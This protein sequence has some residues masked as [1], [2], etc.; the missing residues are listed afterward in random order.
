VR[1]I[2]PLRSNGLTKNDKDPKKKITHTFSWS[3]VVDQIFAA[4]FVFMCVFPSGPCHTDIADNPLHVHKLWRPL[5]LGTWYVCVMAHRVYEGSAVRRSRLCR[6]PAAAAPWR[7]HQYC[8]YLLRHVPAPP[9]FCSLP[10][11][12]PCSRA[13][14]KKTHGV[15]GEECAVPVSV[16]MLC[17]ALYARAITILIASASHCAGCHAQIRRFA[18]HFIV[19]CIWRL[20]R[21]VACSPPF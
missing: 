7:V 1:S 14:S 13:S 20:R 3:E 4:L 8:F 5:G 18:M 6:R 12:I 19:I 2:H 16:P 9:L 11:V 15:R 10:L 21:H 17:S